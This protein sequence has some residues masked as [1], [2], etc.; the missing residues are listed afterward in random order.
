MWISDTV[1]NLYPDTK[2]SD[3]TKY[4]EIPKGTIFEVTKLLSKSCYEVKFDGKTGYIKAEGGS[5]IYQVTSNA[6]FKTV[7]DKIEPEVVANKYAITK[8]IKKV[9]YS[10]NPY[11]VNSVTQSLGESAILDKEYF[12]TCVNKKYYR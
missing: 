10:F 8:D 6:E 12:T 3:S 7:P 5:P 4:T 2:L 1:K 9:K 11:N